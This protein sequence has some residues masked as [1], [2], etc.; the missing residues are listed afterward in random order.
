MR[1]W[2]RYTGVENSLVSGAGARKA[3]GPMEKST[4]E[5]ATG[6]RRLPAWA[7]RGLIALASLIVLPW[8]L[9]PAA[10]AVASVANRSGR[11]APDTRTAGTPVRAVQFSASD[12]VKLSGW[13]A[14]RLARLANNHPRPRLQGN[15]RLDAALGALSLRRQ[16][17]CAAL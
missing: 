16:L 12:G 10:R 9:A 13:L 11:A 4:K 2:V 15:P 6:W 7:R 17:Q 3:I 14:H 1:V 8:T 5:R